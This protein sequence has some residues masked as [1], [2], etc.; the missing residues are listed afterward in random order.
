MNT[1]IQGGRNS[2][3]YQFYHLYALNV[4]YSFASMGLCLL[5]HIPSCR[6]V[7]MK[8]ID[9]LAVGETAKLDWVF[10]MGPIVWHPQATGLKVKALS[11]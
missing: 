6:V 9:S 11:T 7:M 3:T 10:F 4:S 5:C 8:Q 2:S 1:R